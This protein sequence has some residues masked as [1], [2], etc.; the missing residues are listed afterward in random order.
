MEVTNA[1]RSPAPL[2][3]IADS[4]EIDGMTG[5]ITFV[6]FKGDSLDPVAKDVRIRVVAEI[7]KPGERQRFASPYIYPVLTQDGEPVEGMIFEII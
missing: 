2:N 6:S 5:E 3:R 1:D 7:N 4:V